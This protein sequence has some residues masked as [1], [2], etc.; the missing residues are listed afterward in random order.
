MTTTTALHMFKKIFKWIGSRSTKPDKNICRT[1]KNNSTLAGTA[2][3]HGKKY[4]W[5]KMQVTFYWPIA[6]N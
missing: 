4:S 5:K 3:D 1:E 6:N 2:K